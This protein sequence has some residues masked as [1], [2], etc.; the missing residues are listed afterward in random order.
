M[1]TATDTGGAKAGA[2][3]QTAATI[4]GVSA[5]DSVPRSSVAATD[6]PLAGA[7]V[8]VGSAV[9]ATS[10]AAV[11]ANRTATD[12]TFFVKTAEEAT[13]PTDRNSP[14]VPAAPSD[15]WPAHMLP[16]DV[17]A[18]VSAALAEAVAAADAA[19]PNA[20]FKALKASQ[21]ESADVTLLAFS[22]SHA[23]AQ[24]ADVAAV[25]R[26]DVAAGT[27]AAFC[28]NTTTAD[29]A[30]T[31]MCSVASWSTPCPLMILVAMAAARRHPAT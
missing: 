31:L 26:T 12:G 16:A 10:A 22:A 23:D 25:V 21:E 27:A 8:K 17:S 11:T 2:A 20:S 24:Q 3:H 13:G 18:A 4:K 1:P 28:F 14:A 15:D 6:E 30:N 7:E 5:D 9:V 19:T 29:K